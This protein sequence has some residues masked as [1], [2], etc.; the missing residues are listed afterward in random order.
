MLNENVQLVQKQPVLCL[1][2][3]QLDPGEQLAI[4][5]QMERLRKRPAAKNDRKDP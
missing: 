5:K 1:M 3:E 2:K 4:L